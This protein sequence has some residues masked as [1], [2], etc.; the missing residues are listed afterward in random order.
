MLSQKESLSDVQLHL[1]ALNG[2]L[3]LLKR[4][5]D[6]GKVHLDS[7]DKVSIYYTI[8]YHNL[9]KPGHYKWYFPFKEGTT[10]L[11]LAAANGHF[12]CVKELL[13]QGA[14]PKS[15]RIVSENNIRLI[16]LQKFTFINIDHKTL[17]NKYYSL[18][19]LARCIIFK[20]DTSRLILPIF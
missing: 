9:P 11:I 7:K 20:C 4:I 3:N 5:L 6:S 19:H 2:D 10:P 12:D 16:N 14:D 13:E 17:I 1:A 8:D 15:K 18:Y